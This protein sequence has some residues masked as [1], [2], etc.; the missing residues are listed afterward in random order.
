MIRN[1]ALRNLKVGVSNSLGVLLSAALLLVGC[2]SQQAFDPGGI[3]SELDAALEAVA[4]DDDGQ[5]T[6]HALLCIDAPTIDFHYEGAAGIARVDSGEAM[7][8]DR[9][10]F[11]ASVGKPMTAVV[12]YQLAEEGAFGAQGVDATLASLGV[13]QPEALTELHKINGVSFAEAITLRHLLTHT[14]GLR[15]VFFDGIDNPVSLMPGT[16]EGTAPGSLVDLAAFDERYGLGPLVDCT[17]GGQPEGCDP[18]DY[19][20]RH[21]WVPWD[22]D[23]WQADPHDRMAGMLNFYLTGMNE[24]ALW[25]PGGGFH[26][27]DT[28]YILLGLAIEHVTGNSLHRELRARVFDPLGMDETYLVGALDP[29]AALYEKSLSEAWAWDEP[30]ISGGVDFSFDWG[31]GGVVSTAADLHTFTRAL[32]AGE[33]FQGAETLTQMLAV[34]GGVQGISYA[35]GLI[36]FPTGEGPLV[37]MMGSNGT[38]VE[39]YPPMDLVM[40]GTLDDFSNM[41]GQ[42]MLHGQVYQILA[43]HGLR[44]PMAR[45][46]SP[47]MLVAILSLV[48]IMVLALGWLVIA[49]RGRR[50]GLTVP[51]TVRQAHWVTFATLVGNLVLMVLTGVTFG[52]NF[53]QTLFGFSPAVR[54]LFVVTAVLMGG[55]AVAMTSFAIR[56]WRRREGRP[57]DRW[58][59]SVIAT[60]TL[61]YALAMGALVV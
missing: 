42:F 47:A 54:S 24:H 3:A 56:L 46:S 60:L 50:K 33:L 15:D 28:N 57:A 39:Y 31:G 26:Y 7:T 2:S 23:A 4:R 35:S 61:A 37:Y 16:A 48:L 43:D 22:Y 10:F 8:P 29:P 34:P 21:R 11:I 27:S 1:G 36:V 18:D 41:P 14:S 12:I 17:L 51:A 30:A 59:L 44:T 49:R 53:F 38:W 6:R 58:L 55:M 19:L 5:V 45:L 40:I 9:Q 25:E 32:M 13:F 52:G 20:F